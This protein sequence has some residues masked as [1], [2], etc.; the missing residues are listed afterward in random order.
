MTDENHER[1]MH[2]AA[3]EAGYASHEGYVEKY[4][5]DGTVVPT[6]THQAELQAALARAEQFRKEYE[7]ELAEGRIYGAISN[8][9]TRQR[10]AALARAE[11]AKAEL[12]R[13]K[14]ETVRADNEKKR[15]DH[16]EARAEAA[17]R[18]R[19]E[20]I[21]R[22]ERAEE[23]QL[24][25]MR[26]TALAAVERDEAIAASDARVEAMREAC[27]KQIE[28]WTTLDLWKSDGAAAIR[29]LPLPA[30]ET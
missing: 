22:A 25:F 13:L 11:A 19:D 18:Q 26:S 14:L 17:E 20:A 27:A 28:D 2:R 8:E 10:D 9:M 16:Y 15:A 6:D 12:E 5:S 29:R 24:E 30:Q 1:A 3:V 21:A 23:L 7:H 4:K